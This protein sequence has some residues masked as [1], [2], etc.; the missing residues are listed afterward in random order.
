[1]PFNETTILIRQAAHGSMFIA[2]LFVIAIFA[3]YIW[4]ER[5][6]IGRHWYRDP[7]LQASGALLVLF[8]GH[9]IRSGSSWLE[10]MHLQVG[11]H[12]A[13]ANIP[14]IFS[15]AAA[16]ILIGKAL[17]IYAFAPERNLRALIVT[18]VLASVFVPLLVMAMLEI[19]LG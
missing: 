15:I 12:P 13:F 10:F 6:T 9:L 5:K 3:R 4:R 2:N 7:T 11:A 17:V 8:I 14:V 18:M 16:L 19:G 1:M